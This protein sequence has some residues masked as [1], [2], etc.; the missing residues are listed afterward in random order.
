MDGAT[1][2]FNAALSTTI[3]S[4]KA[5]PG[6][7]TAYEVYNPGNALAYIQF[8]DAKAADVV[9]GTTT[10]AWIVPVP[11]GGRVTG[12]HDKLRFL[13]AISAAAATTATGQTAPNA[14]QVAAIGVR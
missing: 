2:K 14:A 1:P 4:L 11:A 9:L 6:L 7:V 12:Q 5:V 10:P 13:T 3:V 8:F